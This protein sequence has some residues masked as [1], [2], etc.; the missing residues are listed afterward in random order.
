ME[1]YRK[2]QK[3]DNKR[4]KNGKKRREIRDS[5]LVVRDSQKR[6]VGAGKPHYQLK[7]VT[8]ESYESYESYEVIT[9]NTDFR[10]P[11]A[12]GSTLL[13]TTKSETPAYCLHPRQRH[14]RT[15]GQANMN[16]QN[17]KAPNEDSAGEEKTVEKGVRRRCAMPRYPQSCEVLV[18]KN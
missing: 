3:I 10:F 7:N 14:S 8:Y 17:R 1:T 18:L 4:Q 9:H 2:R 12:N 6:Y 5:G 15:G 13:T 16:Y 11:I